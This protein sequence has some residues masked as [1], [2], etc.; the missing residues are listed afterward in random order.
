[1]FLHH[2]NYKKWNSNKFHTYETKHKD[3]EPCRTRGNADS[4]NG[5]WVVNTNSCARIN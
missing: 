5:V 2:G 3:N 1:M 4:V